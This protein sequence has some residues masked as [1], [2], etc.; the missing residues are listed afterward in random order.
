[1]SAKRTILMVEHNL[2][3]VANLSDTITVLTRG[4]RAGGGR[5]RHRLEKPATS[6]QRI[7]ESAMLDAT[8]RP[9]LELAVTNL[10]AWYGEIAHPAR[11]RFRRPVPARS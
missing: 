6:R 2:N 1:M 5:L 4:Q 3:V 10:E 11:R 7:W 9:P 8:G